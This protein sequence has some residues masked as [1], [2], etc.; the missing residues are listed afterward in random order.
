[1]DLLF[2]MPPVARIPH[3]TVYGAIVIRVYGVAVCMEGSVCKV[4]IGACEA[5]VWRGYS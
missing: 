5:R 3:L 1:M 2:A 4:N